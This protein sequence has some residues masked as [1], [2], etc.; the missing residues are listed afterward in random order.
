[1][2]SLFTLATVAAKSIRF[3]V[4]RPNLNSSEWELQARVFYSYERSSHN[5]AI[6]CE[7]DVSVK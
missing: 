2:A 4:D 5:V 6:A 1:M 7:V 3:G